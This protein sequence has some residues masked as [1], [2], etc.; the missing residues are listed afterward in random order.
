MCRV[1]VL[2]QF[3]GVVCGLV[4]VVHNGTKDEQMN[5]YR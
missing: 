3:N 5:D 1:R 2:S 4:G